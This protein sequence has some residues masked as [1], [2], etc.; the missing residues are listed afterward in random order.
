MAF[1]L[2]AK[3]IS[4]AR[5]L[6]VL[7]RGVNFR[8]E[9]GAF[10]ALTGPNGSGKTTL[11]R[12]LAGF[13]RP[14]SGAVTASWQGEDLARED[15][16]QA[17]HMLGHRD[18]LKPTLSARAHLAF[19]RDVL[20]G[21]GVGVEE[22][23]ERVGLSVAAPLPARALS[24]GQGRRLALARLLCAPRPLWLLDEPAA[25]LDS[26]GKALL[27]SIIAAHLSGGGAVIAALHEPLGVSS[28]QS[29]TL[30]GVS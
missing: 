19:W 5:G 1:T 6:R 23:L 20:G 13:S 15:R 29:L 14:Q 3:D 10:L 9:A 12:T 26:S 16:A 25:S 24:A 2:E 7:A 4:L 17:L 11:L 22:A 21:G 28:T 27:D 18:G 8:V 30:G